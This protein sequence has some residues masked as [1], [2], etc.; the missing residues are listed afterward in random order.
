[1]SLADD[2][3]LPF[4]V[5]PSIVGSEMSSE[6]GVLLGEGIQLVCNATGVPAPVVQWLK[7]GKTVASDNLQRIRQVKKSVGT[8]FSFCII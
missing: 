6:V 2:P 3:S 7:D 5:P 4:L 8:E 1:M